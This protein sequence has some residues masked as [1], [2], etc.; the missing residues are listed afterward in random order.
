MFGPAV[1][2]QWHE[3]SIHHSILVKNFH[4]NEVIDVYAVKTTAYIIEHTVIV[5]MLHN[6]YGP[7]LN[8]GFFLLECRAKDLGH[9]YVIFVVFRP[10]VIITNPDDIKVNK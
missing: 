10:E 7:I 8:G 9:T 6:I 3:P 2:S 5:G 1:S 4:H